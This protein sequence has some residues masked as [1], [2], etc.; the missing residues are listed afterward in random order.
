MPEVWSAVQGS[1]GIEDLTIAG[2]AQTLTLPAYATQTG[3][4]QIRARIQIRTAPVIWTTHGT[5]PTDQDESTGHKASVGDVIELDTI[6]DIKKFSVIRAT[7]S[8]GS[9]VVRYERRVS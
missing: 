5:G 8:T 2:T 9:G 3:H 7:A 1:D 6:Q 4:A